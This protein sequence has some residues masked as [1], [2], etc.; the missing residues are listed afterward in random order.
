MN[1]QDHEELVSSLL[2]ELPDA[3]LIQ[4]HIS[5]IILSGDVVYKLKKPVDF[6]FLDYTTLEKRHH[7]CLEEL[8]SNRRFAPSLYLG[9]AT[10]TGTPEIPMLE[11]EGEVIDYAVRMRRFDESEQLDHVVDRGALEPEAVDAIAAMVAVFHREAEAAAPESDFG[12]PE[13][14]LA[15]MLENFGLLNELLDDEATGAALADL[16]VWTLE[17]HARLKP[18]LR[19]RKEQG[20][21]RECH[22]DMHLHNMARFKG[23]LI[24][25]DAIEFNPHLSHIDV[26]SD[27]AFLLMDLEY[28]GLPHYSNRLLNAYLERTGDYEGVPLLALYKTYRAMVRAKV[29]ALRSVQN[30]EAAEREAV[31]D[32]VRRYVA[33]A[34]GYARR[35]PPFLAITRGY[36]GSGKSSAALMAV[37]AFGALR[38]RSDVERKRLFGEGEIY[39]PEA[40]QATYKWL[41]AIAQT[42]LEGGRSVVADATFLKQWQRELFETLAAER[43]IRCVILDLECDT[44]LLRDRV[45]QRMAEGRDVSEADLEVLEMQIASAEPLTESERPRRRSVDCTT[46]ASMKAGLLRALE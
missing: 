8:R 42:V 4:T 46:M 6:G 2:K 44:A 27:L 15:P 37:E 34:A 20:F 21:I 3:E 38:I 26:I 24:M 19:A 41:A 9:L 13:R 45:Q 40:T 12:E 5:S 17:Q 11:G 22:G 28:R 18:R 32:E 30:L 7:C 10:V 31:L 35:Q 39:T 14:V 25:F 29:A 23:E 33:L 36:S 1:L 16:K 43:E